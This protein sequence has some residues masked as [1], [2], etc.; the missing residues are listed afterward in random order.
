MGTVEWKTE[1]G[2]WQGELRMGNESGI[3]NETARP[4]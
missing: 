4:V 1:N 3:D 2:K